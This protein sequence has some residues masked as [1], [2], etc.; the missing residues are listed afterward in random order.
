[1]TNPNLIAIQR[2]SQ[3]IPRKINI[4]IHKIEPT[5]FLVKRIGLFVTYSFAAYITNRI[6]TRKSINI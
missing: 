5:Q 2:V 3:N 6:L 1:M 4:N